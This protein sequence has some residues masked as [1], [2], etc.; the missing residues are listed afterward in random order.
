[1]K[2]KRR[3]RRISEK[4]E[5]TISPASPDNPE[6][7]NKVGR[8][9]TEDI[10]I[11]GI[12]IQSEKFFPINSTL[13]IQ[14]SLREPTRLLNVWGKIRWVKKLKE[15]EVFEMGIEIVGTSKEDHGF[16]KR[17]IEDSLET[18][19]EKNFSW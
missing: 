10:S 13:K 6:L 1:M 15:C 12:K 17:H 3:A 7:D 2:E 19:K 8:C 5:V 4:A 18:V 14:L 9:L 16:L 11:N